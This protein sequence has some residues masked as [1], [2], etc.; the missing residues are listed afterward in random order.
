[1]HQDMG[2]LLLGATETILEDDTWLTV[3]KCVEVL[4]MW[5][6]G[7]IELALYMVFK[8]VVYHDRDIV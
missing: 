2:H 7:L 6:A 3:G 5:S 4:F 1:M 8:A